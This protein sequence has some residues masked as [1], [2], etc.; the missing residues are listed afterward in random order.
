[1]NIG[2][3]SVVLNYNNSNGLS[4]P[5]L[6]AKIN[7][8]RRGDSRFGNLFGMIF[9]LYLNLGYLDQNTHWKNKPV[10]KK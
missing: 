8:H 7:K 6:P 3:L 2:I 4:R 9:H 5:S 10:Q 1:M